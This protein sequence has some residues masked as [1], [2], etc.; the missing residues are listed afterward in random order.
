MKEI[1]TMATEYKHLTMAIHFMR[2]LFKIRVWKIKQ[3]SLKNSLGDS[4]L[5]DIKQKR[6]A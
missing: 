2:L 5:L 4:L 3:A 6:K 1:M